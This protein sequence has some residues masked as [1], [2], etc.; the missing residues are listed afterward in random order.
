[1]QHV[2]GA[3]WKRLLQEV[4]T[5]TDK[6]KLKQETE[7]LEAAIFYRSQELAHSADDH[8]EKEAIRQATVSLLQIRVDMLDFPLD[9]KILRSIRDKQVE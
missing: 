7:D 3:D 5:E 2:Q 9:P 6:A 1:M 8:A 4:M